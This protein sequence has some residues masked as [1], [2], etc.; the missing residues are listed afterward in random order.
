[1]LGSGLTLRDIFPCQLPDDYIMG[2]HALFS[3]CDHHHACFYLIRES[4]CDL[5]YLMPRGFYLFWFNYVSVFGFS[6]KTSISQ[7]FMSIP[8]DNIVFSNIVQ[9]F[10]CYTCKEY[11]ED[12]GKIP[13]RMLQVND[14]KLL[15]Q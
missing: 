9:N 11:V 2:C 8:D 3:V 5:L 1:M 6:N 13:Q 4:F 14:V 12:L 10:L 7:L 15:C